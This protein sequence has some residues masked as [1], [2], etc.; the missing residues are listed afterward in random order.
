ML[1]GVKKY[2][3]LQMRFLIEKKREIFIDKFAT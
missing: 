3:V 2:F 1:G